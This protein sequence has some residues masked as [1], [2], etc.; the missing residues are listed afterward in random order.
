MLCL[1]ALTP[2]VFTLVGHRDLI[3]PAGLNALAQHWVRRGVDIKAI[4]IATGE[5]RSCNDRALVDDDIT[6]RSRHVPF[7]DAVVRRVGQGEPKSLRLGLS[8]NRGNRKTDRG[9]LIQQ[10]DQ[11]RTDGCCDLDSGNSP[12]FGKLGKCHSIRSGAERI[13]GKK[14]V[15]ADGRTLG[16]NEDVICTSPIRVQGVL[17]CGGRG[18]LYARCR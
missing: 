7:G 12:Y 3:K 1:R 14:T 18:T 13:G 8:F 17:E 11:Y 6:S 16:G 2:L 10:R 9:C 5:Y 4:E 15:G